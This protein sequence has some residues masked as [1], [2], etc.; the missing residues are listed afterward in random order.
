MPADGQR[1][2]TLYLTSC[3]QHARSSAGVPMV[4]GRRFTC[5][6]GYP[7]LPWGCGPALH[8]NLKAPRWLVLSGV[9]AA[10]MPGGVRILAGAI[11]FDGGLQDAIRFLHN[12][13]A[14]SMPYLGRGRRGDAFAILSAGALGRIEAADSLIAAA[15]TE[16]KVT[17]AAGCTVALGQKGRGQFA[18]FG[19]IAAGDA[20]DVHG[21]RFSTVAAG[22]E[23][24]VDV[25]EGS[26][27]AVAG[28]STVRAG[29]ASRV[30]VESGGRLDR[31]PRAVGV[32][33]PTTQFRGAE[34][35]L[36]V[37]VNAPDAGDVGVV[38]ARVGTAGVNAGTWYRYS[39]GAFVEGDQHVR[40]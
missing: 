15:G 21:A 31:G 24:E 19:R 38:Q 30:V 12:N 5:P 32:G 4:A 40:R 27:V 3:D 35:A 39:D 25:G 20:A 37:V 33:S 16:S 34:G 36:F 1:L 9:E 8:L 22:N 14:A 23:S 18:E 13:G 17:G 26:T 11:E 6:D 28:G 29:A 7:A 10:P 2:Q